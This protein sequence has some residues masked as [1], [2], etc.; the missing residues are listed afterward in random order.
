MTVPLDKQSI[1]YR[2]LLKNSGKYA[3]IKKKNLME[4]GV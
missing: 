3:I 1:F 2:F 4:D